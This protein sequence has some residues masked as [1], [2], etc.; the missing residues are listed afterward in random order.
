MEVVRG[1][2]LTPQAQSTGLR[3]QVCPADPPITPSEH[4]TDRVASGSQLPPPKPQMQVTISVP[5]AQRDDRRV[6]PNG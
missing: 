4:N 2:G 5:C 1:Y 3:Y 6:H